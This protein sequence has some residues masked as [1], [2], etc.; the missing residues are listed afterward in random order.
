MSEDCS[1]SV[2]VHECLLA[3][4]HLDAKIWKKDFN[5]QIGGKIAGPFCNLGVGGENTS[6]ICLHSLV[7]MAAEVH[8]AQAEQEIVGWRGQ[9]GTNPFLEPAA[10]KGVILQLGL[11][12]VGNSH[13]S[14]SLESMWQWWV[15]VVGGLQLGTSH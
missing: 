7:R 15:A 8:G 12:E 1:L 6:H 2:S 10:D 4:E 3:A 5:I 14:K 13:L 9:K 11:A